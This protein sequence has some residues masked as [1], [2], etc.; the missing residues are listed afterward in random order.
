M[1]QTQQ[2]AALLREILARDHSNYG[3]NYALGMLYHRSGRND[4]AIPLLRKAVQIRPD[5]FEAALNLG[6]IELGQGLLADAQKHLNKAVAII[7]DSAKAHA[8]LGTLHVVRNDVDAAIAALSRALELEPEDADLN[9]QM[10]MLY[11]SHG[12]SEQA[13]YYYRKAISHRPLCG[14]AHYGLAFL[15]RFTE[16]NDDISRMERAYQSA[17]MTDEDRILIGFALGKAYDDLTQY[18]KAFERMHEAN[19][20]QRESIVYSF[21]EQRKFFERHSQALNEEF[22]DHCNSCCVTDETPVFVLG[23][24]RSGTSLVEQILASHPMVHGAGEVEYSRLFAEE[25]R[26]LT[27]KPFP[28]NIGTIAAEK[29]REFGLAYIERLR[30]DAGSAK[31]VI[32]KLP[33]NFLRVGLFAAL[34]PKAKFIVCSRNP[35]DNC[36]SIYQRHFSAGHG[37]ATDLTELGEYYRLYEELMLHWQGLFPGR[38]HRLIYEELVEDTEDQIRKLLEYCEL[39]FHDDCLAFHSTRR[40]VSTPSAS[41]VREPIYRNAVGRARNYEGHLQPLLEALSR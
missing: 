21:D 12:E 26:K 16:S 37:Y 4:L 40:I 8:T 30:I 32:D 5:V 13:A 7:P 10:A 31:H 33:H 6:I 2:A 34:M 14:D 20:L 22:V 35:M 28:Q 15:Q 38:I 24:P 17:D 18:D 11:A 29:L 9:T 3:A 19:R 27:G 36:L 25:V 39:P 41:Q 23:M 1:G